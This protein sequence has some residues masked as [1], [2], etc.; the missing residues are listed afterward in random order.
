MK[1]AC[2]ERITEILRYSWIMWPHFRESKHE[3]AR[4]PT[5]LSVSRGGGGRGRKDSREER[6]YRSNESTEWVITHAT[7][8]SVRFRSR[9]KGRFTTELQ[10][11]GG[12]V[13]GREGERENVKMGAIETRQRFKGRRAGLTFV[14]RELNY[15]LPPLPVYWSPVKTVQLWSTMRN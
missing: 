14:K 15:P 4:F 6:F 2:P 8:L 13:Q 9:L 3:R 11:R 12:L 1:N 7:I 5:G 10:A